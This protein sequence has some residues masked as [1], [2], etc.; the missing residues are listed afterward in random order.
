MISALMEK[1]TLSKVKPTAGFPLNSPEP[2]SGDTVL[3]N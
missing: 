3:I 2:D 1:I